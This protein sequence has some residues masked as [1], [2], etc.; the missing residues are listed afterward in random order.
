ML[1]LCVC[2]C[3]DGLCPVGREFLEFARLGVATNWFGLG[4]PIPCG[5]PTW[6]TLGL[7]FVL[8]L[9]LGAQPSAF[10]F[11]FGSA[12]G[13]WAYPDLQPLLPLVIRLT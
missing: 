7:I 3:V 10:S 2:V 11:S 13:L 4:C 9:S 8:G 6:F 5:Q 1:K 12:I